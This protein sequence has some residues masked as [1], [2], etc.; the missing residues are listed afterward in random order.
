MPL[1]DEAQTAL[2]FSIC[3]PLPWGFKPQSL[4]TKGRGSQ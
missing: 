3:C 1:P 4:D 2:T